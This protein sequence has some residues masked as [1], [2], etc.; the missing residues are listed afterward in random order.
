[1][2]QETKHDNLD[3]KLL[4]T[5]D[6][7]RQYVVDKVTGADIDQNIIKSIRDDISEQIER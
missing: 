6:T 4:Y 7:D 3:N 2:Q 5:V 1:M